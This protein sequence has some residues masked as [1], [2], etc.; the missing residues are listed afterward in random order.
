MLSDG[1]LKATSKEEFNLEPA[2]QT[3]PLSSGHARVPRRRLSPAIS[4]ECNTRSDSTANV[5]IN[6]LDKSDMI[7]D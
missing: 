5:E 3:A 2:D 6:M 1:M 7:L 4:L